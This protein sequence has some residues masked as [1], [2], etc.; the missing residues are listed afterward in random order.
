[1]QRILALEGITEMVSLE[2]KSEKKYMTNQLT[3]FS[4]MVGLL[5]WLPLQTR[6]QVISKVD[7]IPKAVQSFIAQEN[8]EMADMGSVE[9]FKYEC[10]DLDN[11]NTATDECVLLWQWMTGS[12]WSV[13][14]SIIDSNG[15]ELDSL[16]FGRSAMLLSIVPYS[17]G[18][19]I[20]IEH[21]VAQGGDVSCCPSKLNIS[22]YRLYNGQ[23]QQLS[24]SEL[25]ETNRHN[26]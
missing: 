6:G 14:L 13:S 17:K 23:L 24:S 11:D 10:L 22:V 19:L 8:K 9:L 2:I 25:P 5:M 12:T 3:L 18:S 4:F 7:I 20:I 21:A 26:Q 15:K 1:M 16:T